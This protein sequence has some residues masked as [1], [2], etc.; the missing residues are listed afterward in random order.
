MRFIAA[1]KAGMQDQTIADAY[2]VGTTLTVVD[3]TMKR[4]QLTFADIGLLARIEET[5]RER[6][7]I[8]EDGSFIYWPSGDVH[9]N[10][11]M[12][13]DALEPEY[14]ARSLKESAT[15]YKQLG[16]AI[17]SVRKGRGLRQSDIDGISERH[18]RRLEQGSP[19]SSATMKI[20]AAGHSMR[21]KA[22]LDEIAEAMHVS[23]ERLD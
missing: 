19:V 5:E 9:L 18:L 21:L 22:Y 10:I 16:R 15:E 7:E 20:L 11:D 12:I 1:W 13:R 3:C 4:Y 6:F 23:A 8:D 2:V 14:R 17:A